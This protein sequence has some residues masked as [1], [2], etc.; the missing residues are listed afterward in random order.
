[1]LQLGEK[2]YFTAAPTLSPSSC[3]V[4]KR[5]GIGLFIIDYLPDTYA[6]DC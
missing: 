1:M 5:Y 3:I 2:L 4:R 6:S